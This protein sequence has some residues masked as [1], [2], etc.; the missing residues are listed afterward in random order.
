M[1]TSCCFK[2]ALICLN[3][4]HTARPHRTSVVKSLCHSSHF[5]AQKNDW[6]HFFWKGCDMA[7]LKAEWICRVELK[8]LK[9]SRKHSGFSLS[10]H[11][12][13]ASHNHYLYI[14]SSMEGGKPK[15]YHMPSDFFMWQPICVLTPSFCGSESNAWQFKESRAA[16]GIRHSVFK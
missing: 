7:Q 5:V 8:C 11:F 1:E 13:L 15:R 6:H 16:Y 2:M 12:C 4:Y 14:I 3:C 10:A 9:N